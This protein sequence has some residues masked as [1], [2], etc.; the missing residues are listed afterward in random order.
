MK[1]LINRNIYIYRNTSWKTL[2]C[3]VK[4]MTACQSRVTFEIKEFSVWHRKGNSVLVIVVDKTGN[5]ALWSITNL[6]FTSHSSQS[7]CHISD[8]Q[9]CR[10][11]YCIVYRFIYLRDVARTKCL[12][13]RRRNLIAVF[14]SN[15][16]EFIQVSIMKSLKN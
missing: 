1:H 7:T 6:C 13:H 3:C 8:E 5:Y 16:I 2:W 9:C 11:R 14:L 12:T 10:S 15:L 4:S